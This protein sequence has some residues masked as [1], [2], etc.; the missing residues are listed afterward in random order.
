MIEK[1]N[2]SPKLIV[3]KIIC[4]PFWS[5][6]MGSP[7]LVQTRNERRKPNHPNLSDFIFNL[8]MLSGFLNAIK[9]CV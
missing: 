1:V 7:S 2:L 8:N 4:P 9:I 3:P 6:R 5:A